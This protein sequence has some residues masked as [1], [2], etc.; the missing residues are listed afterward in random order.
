MTLWALVKDNPRCKLAL[1]AARVPNMGSRGGGGRMGGGGG[2]SGTSGDVLMQA[3][4]AHGQTS[5]A[6]LELQI[7]PEP[8][9]LNP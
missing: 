8:L 2:G 9:T 4:A 7:N 6:T 5:E 3:L 1:M